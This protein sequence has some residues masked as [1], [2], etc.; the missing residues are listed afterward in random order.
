MTN[1]QKR[2][3]R[4]AARL[5]GLAAAVLAA[6]AL[7]LSTGATSA[8][9]APADAEAV[10]LP[11]GVIKLND[12]EPCPMYTLCLYRDYNFSGPAYGVA[13]GYPVNLHELPMAAPGGSAADNVS[14]WVNYTRAVAVLGDDDTGL[15]RPLFPGQRLQEPP[16]TNDTVDHIFW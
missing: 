2:R 14:S 13:E 6:M 12:S 5:A 16:V 4:T 9:A 10:P 15:T 3:T 8:A 7:P 1:T 11:P